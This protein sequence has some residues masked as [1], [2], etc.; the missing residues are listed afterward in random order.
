[1]REWTIGLVAL[2]VTTL[3]AAPADA[4]S[5]RYKVVKA[6]AGKAHSHVIKLS[7][8][9]FGV[10]ATQDREVCEYVELPFLKGLTSCL[11]E[12]PGDPETCGLPI[13]GYD[14]RMKGSGTSHHFILWAYEGSAEGA[15]AFPAGIHDSKAC[16]DFGPADS[17]NTRQIGGS[18]TRRLRALLPSGLGQQVK[19]LTGPDGTP[20]GIGLILNSHFIGSGEPA[21]GAVKIQLYVA[22]PGSIRAY[23]KLIFDVLASAFI[24]VPPGTVRTTSGSWEVG[25]AVIPI[26]GGPP[27][28]DACVLF[29]TAHMHRR[30][31]KFTT[32]LVD[33]TGTQPIYQTVDYADPGQVGFIPPKLMTRGMRFQ[34]ECTHDNGVAKLLKLG[35]ELE[36]GV[37]PGV[38][39]WRAF[40]DGKLDGSPRSCASDADC[41]GIGTGRCVPANLVWGFTSNDDMCI[42]PGMYYDAIPG[43]P[44]G[45]ECDLSLL[46]PL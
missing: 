23:G 14:I 17:I 27:A 39:L 22:R 30:G 2:L 8:G 35:C 9:P 43:A 28:N 20:T 33:A 42:L 36:P 40:L 7:V 44:P 41:T 4:R 15:A 37:T 29:L 21:K 38:P 31:V 32:D 19:A 25:G 24:E 16:L 26:V 34:Y 45:Q 11:R 46:P 12:K 13:V 3:T 18:Q 10:G 5:K 6:P 1:M